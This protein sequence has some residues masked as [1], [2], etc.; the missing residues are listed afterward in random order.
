MPRLLLR[1]G[2]A[3]A[4][5]MLLAAGAA[6]WLLL[7]LGYMPRS[8]A[9]YIERRSSGHNPLITG[10]G[11]WAGATLRNMD[12]GT[13]P[14]TLPAL[15]LGAQA[16]AVGHGAGAMKRVS[17]ANGAYQAFAAALAGDVITFA[18]GVYRFERPLVANR[19]GTSGAPVTVRAPTP[20][21]V[22]LEFDTVEGVLVEAPYWRFENLVLR[23]V[24]Q[25]DDY[26][27]HAFHVVGRGVG[28]VAMNNTLLDFNAHIKVNGSRGMFP[29]RGLV[30]GNTLSN[31]R[32]RHTANPVTPI[33]LVAAS[34]W[35]FRAN[36]VTDFIKTAGDGV[37]Y[38]AFAK[39]AGKGNVFERNIF[40][41]EQRLR[42]HPGQR[43][44]VSLGGG[45]TDQAYC[46]DGRCIVEQQDGVIRDNLIASCSDAGIYLNSAA[47][48]AIGHNTVVDTAGVDV[49]YPTSSA[50]IAGNLVEGPIRS[51]DGGVV[52][53]AQNHATSLLWPYLGVHPVRS[54]FRDWE[55]ADLAW[56]DDAPGPAPVTDRP[57]LC[58]AARTGQSAVGAFEDFG[59][60]LAAPEARPAVTNPALINPAL[61]NPALTKAGMAA[62]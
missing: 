36:L 62:N 37:S 43:V 30:Q 45:G 61:T 58:G 52:R 1:A 47:A 19:P 55:R 41:C 7:H 35:I 23:G 60:C 22:T 44:G 13:M 4:V 42:G 6:A 8:L 5:L 53:L 59:A 12:R 38:G 31:S 24:C 17:D 33:D 54:L 40:W 57:D 27:E 21:S 56:R 15:A 48:S 39:G 50:D 11:S 26:C 25:V 10:T 16:H 3:A 2:V 9:P 20:G 29:D 34:G 28:F 14:V 49:R 32:P 46:R 18:P 51:R